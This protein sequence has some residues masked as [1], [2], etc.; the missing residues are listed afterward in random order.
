M[1]NLRVAKNRII[2]VTYSIRAEDGEILEQS[3]L[4]VSYL[5]GGQTRLFAKVDL[6]LQGCK[7]GDSVDV[8][9]APEDG[10]GEYDPG[11]TFT[12]DLENVPEEFRK[13]GAEVEMQNEDGE[14]RTFYVSKIDDDT[15]T[16]DGNHIFAGKTVNFHVKVGSIREATEQELKSGVV[17]NPGLH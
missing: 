1:S 7:E 13:I 10:F 8:R 4:P 12:D 5:Q 3:D 2:S 6:A 16:V 15:L 9:L 14:S 17:T 11:L